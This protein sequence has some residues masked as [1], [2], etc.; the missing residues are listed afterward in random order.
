MLVG[1]CMER[2]PELIVAILAILKAGGAYVPLDPDYP[3]KR[4]SFMIRDSRTS[5]IVAHRP[6]ARRLAPALCQAACLL[7]R[8]VRYRE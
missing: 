8:F 3:D 4:L 7:D 5:L 2:S 1:L 6:T